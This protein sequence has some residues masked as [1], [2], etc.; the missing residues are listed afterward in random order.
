M[1]YSFYL[2]FNTS[3]PAFTTKVKVKET[4][5]KCVADR[6]CCISVFKC[7]GKNE[8][9]KI[10]L[11]IFLVKAN[12]PKILLKFSFYQLLTSKDFLLVQEIYSRANS[13]C[14]FDRLMAS[15]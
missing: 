7:T 14:Q 4:E 13:K 1:F 9:V 8:N 11:I 2:R 12:K 6:H 3:G 15:V 5:E 10:F